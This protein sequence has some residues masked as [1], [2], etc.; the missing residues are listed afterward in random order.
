LISLSCFNNEIV[1]KGTTIARA[2]RGSSK[3][4]DFAPTTSLA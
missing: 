2:R 4:G 1:R 3:T